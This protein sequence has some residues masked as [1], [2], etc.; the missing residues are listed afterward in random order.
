MKANSFIKSQK[1]YRH[2]RHLV[3]Q[4]VKVKDGVEIKNTI[5]ILC[6]EQLNSLVFSLARVAGYGTSLS[7]QEIKVFKWRSGTKKALHFKTPSTTEIG[8]EEIYFEKQTN[9]KKLNIN[10]KKFSFLLVLVL[11]STQCTELIVIIPKTYR[12]LYSGRFSLK[13]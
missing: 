5:Q 10:Y 1:G 2:W 6:K 12:Q 13:R 3:Q 9:K 8:E 7:Q 4:M 11:K